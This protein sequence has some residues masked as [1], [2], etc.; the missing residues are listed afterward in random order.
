MTYTP[1]RITYLEIDLKSAKRNFEGGY[2]RATLKPPDY[3][4][5]EPLFLELGR[6]SLQLKL[7]DRSEVELP[8]AVPQRTEDTL[9]SP[10]HPVLRAVGKVLRELGVSL[11][12]QSVYEPS[13]L[14]FI[15]FRISTESAAFA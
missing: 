9:V 1:S 12:E 15:T 2:T 3:R 6:D 10:V 5:A 13:R 8:C 11:N 7:L 14:H 4:G